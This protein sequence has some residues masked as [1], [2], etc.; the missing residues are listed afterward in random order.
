[1]PGTESSTSSVQ[2]ALNAKGEAQITAKVYAGEFRVGAQV[3]TAEVGDLPDTAV[4][5]V[6]RTG[7]SLER[8]GITVPGAPLGGFEAALKTHISS[9]ETEHLAAE[10]AGNGDDADG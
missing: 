9:L 7:M 10:L 3:E 5:L 4:A 2:I 1:M 8:I 6:L